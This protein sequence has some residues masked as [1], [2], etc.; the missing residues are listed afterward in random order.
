[1]FIA[2]LIEH[3][4][5]NHVSLVLNCENLLDYRQSKKE[6]LFFGTITNPEFRPLWAPIDGR[7]TNLA[8]RIKK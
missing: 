7:V 1:L 2:A 8:L 6:Q 3:K 5:G 4:F